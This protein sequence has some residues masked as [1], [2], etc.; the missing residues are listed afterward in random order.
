M[1]AFFLLFL[2]STTWADVYSVSDNTARTGW[3][4]SEPALAP[5]HVASASV[6]ELFVTDL[7]MVAGNSE[8]GL[9]RQQILG[10][11]LVADGYLIVATEENRVYGLN[12]ATGAIR[13]TRYLGPSWPVATIGC[14]DLVPDIGVTSTP[15]YDP[16]N[17]NLYVL[18]K[19]YDEIGRAH[20]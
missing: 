13:W 5:A 2:A 18:S 8:S 9:Q 15:V 6:G 1:L 10:Q 16:S 19:T 14:K 20:V 3:D 4:A 7:P 12:P 17:H 11:P